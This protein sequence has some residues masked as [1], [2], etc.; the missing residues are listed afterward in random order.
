MITYCVHLSNDGRNRKS[1]GKAPLTS[2]VDKYCVRTDHKSME[3]FNNPSTPQ[4]P[5]P[6]QQQISTQWIEH[7]AL[8]ELNMDE[9]GVVHLD[10]HLNPDHLLEESSIHFMDQIRDKVDVYVQAFNNY[11]GPQAGAQIKI[12]KISNTVNDFM[13]FRNSLR[14]IFARKA[15]DLI[16][17]G[18]LASG[19]DLFS[20]R[21][22]QNEGQGGSVPHEIV[23]HLGPF[24]KITWRFQGEEVDVDALVRH[25]LS[26]FIRN[27]AR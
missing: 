25:Y 4:N 16:T 11:R 18:F 9:T 1:T 12:F 19:K 14:L 10:D 24:H 6:G 27:S 17:V 20:A 23:A 26:E 21:L 8:E 13:L 3:S 2:K 7:L 15:H 22:S 5:A